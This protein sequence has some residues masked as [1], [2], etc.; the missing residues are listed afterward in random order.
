MLDHRHS[1]HARVLER[2]A[3][4]DRGRHRM[5]VVGDRHAAGLAEVANVGEQ[6]AFRRP[7]HRADRI[8]ARQVRFRCFRQDVRRHIRIVVDRV[9]VRHAGDGGE[10]AGDSRGRAGR[11]R[12][13]VLLPRLAQVHVHIDEPRANHQTVG[14]RHDRGSVHRQIDAD[15][16]DAVA[17]DQDVAHAV[18][19]VGGIDH[20]SA[21]K[22]PLHVPLHRPAG[23][24]PPCAPRRRWRPV[25]ESPSKDRPRL[26]TRSPRRGSSAPGA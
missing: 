12:F 6:L 13:L 15:A 25:R 2:A 19:P 20:A 16:R 21:L 14:H 10:T 11:D 17:V 8:H 5:A 1:E 7:R 9:R 23:T 4:E 24:T 3:Q 26:P 22:Q 18:D